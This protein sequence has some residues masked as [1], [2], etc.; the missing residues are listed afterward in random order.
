[1]SI[2]CICWSTKRG[3]TRSI[4]DAT[5]LLRFQYDTLMATVYPIPTKLNL[6]ILTLQVVGF[7]A[8]VFATAMSSRWWQ[9]LGLS[10]VFAIL[11]NSI[12]SIIHEAEHG[13][14]HPN[15]KLNDLLGMSMAIL[16]P[17]PFHLI[18]QGHLGHHRRNRSDDE[19]FD[20]YFDGD[21]PWLKWLILYGILT[22]FYWMLVVLSNV[23]VLIVPFLFKRRFF[24]F[25]RP[26]AAFM[27]AL[28]PRVFWLIQVEAVVT[29]L[30]HGAI[31]Y[32]F[33]IP[34]LHYAIVYFG[35]GFSW[36]AMQYVHHF[37]TERDVLN[38]ARNLR[39]FRWIDAVWLYHN[40]HLIHHQRPNI[41]WIYLPGLS[42]E[43]PTTRDSLVWHYV[44]MWRG[45]RYTTL[46]VKQTTS[47]R[48]AD[49]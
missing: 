27:D 30:F 18:R 20:L 31:L 40:W 13:M 5:I 41:P 17:A 9:L 1:M 34:F 32:C 28:N 14:L 2:G 29:I 8:I 45:P 19:A 36:S 10:I 39:F 35:F 22:G 4:C 12:Y 16:F 7:G 21:R 37:G 33:P 23:A 48:Q 24:E 3:K 38:G 11:G 43:H 46:R 6:A 49:V 47:E 15:R 25:D 44:R 42:Q 26:S